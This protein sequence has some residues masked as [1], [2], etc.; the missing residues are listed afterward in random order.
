MGDINFQT[1][2]TNKAYVTNSRNQSE[3]AWKEETVESSRYG[4][5]ARSSSATGKAGGS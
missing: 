4:T 5:K 1:S 3:M 2:V